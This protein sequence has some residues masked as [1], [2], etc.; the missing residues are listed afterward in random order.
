MNGRL[1]GNH[2]LTQ[3]LVSTALPVVV[4][5]QVTGVGSAPPHEVV[6]APHIQLVHAHERGVSNSRNTGLKVIRADWVVL[7]DDDV[8]LLMDGLDALHQHLKSVTEHVGAVATRLM[9]GPG[10]PWRTYDPNLKVIKGRGWSAKLAIQHINSMEL[11]LNRAQMRDAGMGFNP[12][13][14]LGAPPTTG[15]EEVLMLS[16]I[17]NR[18]WAVQVLPVAT[19][20]H[21]GESSGSLW[22]EGAAFS[23]GAVHRLTFDAPS[24]WLL[25]PWSLAKRLF[26]GGPSAHWMAYVRGWWWASRHR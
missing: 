26:Q 17:L 10:L 7:C 8:T 12:S 5:D 9:K 20:M 23:Q 6:E 14:G 11:V 16:N 2:A 4:V 3:Q 1:W 24:R 19:R 22:N 15:G 25:L 18:G 21:P 13:F